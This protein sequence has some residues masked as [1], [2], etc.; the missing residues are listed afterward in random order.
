MITSLRLGLHF[1]TPEAE[2]LY[3]DAGYQDTISSGF[4]LVNIE[5]VVFTAENR[6]RLVNLGVVIDPPEGYHSL[7]LPR[8]SLYTK[9]QVLQTNG[10]GLVDA[11]FKGKND[12]WRIP[13]LF[14]PAIASLKQMTIPKGTRICQFFLQPVFRFETYKYTPAEESRGGNGSTD[15]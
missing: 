14:S 2:T 11:N 13:L 3:K 5:E 1:V 7:L 6:F 15:K 4:D 8:S 12:I 10:I 9:F